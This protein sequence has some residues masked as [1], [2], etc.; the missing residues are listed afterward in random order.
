MA[1][2][3]MVEVIPCATEG[4][5]DPGGQ[6][7]YQRAQGTFSQKHLAT[8]SETVVQGRDCLAMA[9]QDSDS[10]A[11]VKIET[12]VGSCERAA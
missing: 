3:E 7:R 6:A 2:V 1:V 12:T 9:S 5:R 8:Q 10:T 4:W 11:T